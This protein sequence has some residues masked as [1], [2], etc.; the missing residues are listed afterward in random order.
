MV[1]YGEFPKDRWECCACGKRRDFHMLR[2]PINYI[3]R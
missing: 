3:P 2:P 1:G